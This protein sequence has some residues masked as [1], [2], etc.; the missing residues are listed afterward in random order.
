MGSGHEKRNSMSM[1]LTPGQTPPGSRRGTPPPSLGHAAGQE[2]ARRSRERSGSPSALSRGYDA[3]D[4]PSGVGT[5]SGGS[6]GQ[7]TPNSVVG[8]AGTASGGGYN[9]ERAESYSWAWTG[10]KDAGPLRRAP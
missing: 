5:G 2:F 3:R 10:N 9:R 7:G 8:G 6:S 1:L 4:S